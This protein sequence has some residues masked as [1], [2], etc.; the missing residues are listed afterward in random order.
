MK[1]TLLVLISYCLILTGCSAL[2]AGEAEDSGFLSSP[3][4][5]EKNERFPFHKWWV[6]KGA[7]K[8]KGGKVFLAPVNLTYLKKTSDWSHIDY[9]SEQEIVEGAQKLGQYFHQRLTEELRAEGTRFQ[10]VESEKGADG[11]LEVA[12]VELVPTDVGRNVV[13]TGVGTFVPGGSLISVGSSGS[14]AIE[15]RFRDLRTGEVVAE[16][17]DREKGRIAPVDL[18][19][20]TSFRI[21]ER[22][23]DDWAE[24]IV[25][26]LITPA[27]AEVSDSSPL[28]LLPW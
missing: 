20:F 23:V 15:G 4:R 1:K 7:V 28:T 22:A 12:I 27:G 25:E 18:T 3:E 6:K 16:F 9:L 19:G 21:A 26:I 10:V 14:I 8:S 2:K 13:G 17:K 11:S 24:Q 5:L